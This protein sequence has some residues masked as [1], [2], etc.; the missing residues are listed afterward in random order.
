MVRSASSRVSNHELIRFSSFE[1]PR[2]GA[3]PQ[4]LRMFRVRCENL[5]SDGPDYAAPKCFG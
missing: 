1:T 4:S 5:A 2:K 3:A